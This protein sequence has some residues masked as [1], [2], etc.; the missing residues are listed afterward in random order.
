MVTQSS[1]SDSSS[2]QL[3]V[4]STTSG[5]VSLDGPEKSKSNE[6]PVKPVIVTVDKTK[7]KIKNLVQESNITQ[8]SAAQSGGTKKKEKDTLS[9]Y[10]NDKFHSGPLNPEPYDDPA[11]YEVGDSN[12]NSAEKYYYQDPFMVSMTRSKTLNPKQSKPYRYP[13]I[14]PVSETGGSGQGSPPTAPLTDYVEEDYESPD[15]Y[16]DFKNLP[17]IKSALSSPKYVGPAPYRYPPYTS[18]YPTRFYA[19]YDGESAP[20]KSQSSGVNSWSGLAGFLLGIL[21]LGIL[22]ASMVPAF[23]SVPVASA[24]AGVGR[25]KRSLSRHDQ[26]TKLIESYEKTMMKSEICVKQFLCNALRHSSSDTK[27]KPYYT[28]IESL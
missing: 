17:M 13:D 27:K 15:S 12:A 1:G 3:Q 23:V 14:V 7:P 20:G 19:P 25:K 8:P 2:N 11:T 28:S 18:Y 10:I 21:P 16:S 5:S 9:S 26:M 24:A 4:S 6:S 22:M